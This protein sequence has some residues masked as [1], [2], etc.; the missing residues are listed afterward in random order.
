MI[1]S[2]QNGGET[3]HPDK[4]LD[5]LGPE[6]VVDKLILARLHSFSFLFFLI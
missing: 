3:R 1:S 4:V 6:V 5:G 2:I